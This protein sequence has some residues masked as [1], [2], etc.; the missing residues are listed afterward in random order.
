M[1]GHDIEISL[2]DIQGDQV[3]LGIKAPR[4]VAVHRKEI[5][6]EIRSENQLATMRSRD[7]IDRLKG[8]PLK[9]D[10]EPEA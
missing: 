9:G 2:I 1:I 6:E 7:V 8:R 5:Y 10:A 3:R 4:S